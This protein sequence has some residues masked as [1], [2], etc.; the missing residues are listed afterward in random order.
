MSEVTWYSRITMRSIY[1][2]GGTVRSNR[3]RYACPNITF[4]ASDFNMLLCKALKSAGQKEFVLSNGNHVSLADIYEYQPIIVCAEIMSC[5]LTDIQ[6]AV[7][8]I[9]SNPSGEDLIKEKIKSMLFRIEDWRKRIEWASIQESYSYMLLTDLHEYIEVRWSAIYQEMC[10][11]FPNLKLDNLKGVWCSAM[12]ND[13]S[14]SSAQD[15]LF[16][17]GHQLVALIE[18]LQ[19]R[20]PIYMQEIMHNGNMDPSLSM[21]VYFLSKYAKMADSFNQR[22][23]GINDFYYDKVLGVKCREERNGKFWISAKIAHGFSPFTLPSNTRIW[24]KR[25]DKPICGRTLSDLVLT[26]VELNSLS[27]LEIGKVKERHPESDLNYVTNL[28]LSSFYPKDDDCDKKLGIGLRSSIF[29]LAGGHRHIKIHYVLTEDSVFFF[30]DMIRQVSQ[31]QQISE[32]EAQNKVLNESTFRVYLSTSVGLLE[33]GNFMMDYYETNTE[34]GISI[35]IELDSNFPAIDVLEGCSNPEIRMLVSNR[36]WLYPYSWCRKIKM[37]KVKVSVAV[38]GLRNFQV[39]NDLGQVD[40]TQ[41]FSPFGSS[42]V[43]GSWFVV[44]SEEMLNKR[45]SQVDLSLSWRGLPS[46]R[47]GMKGYY[48]SYVSNDSEIIDNTSFRVKGEYLSGYSWK[49]SLN[50]NEQYMFRTSLDEIPSPD[51]ALVEKS[52][53]SLSVPTITDRHLDNL[54]YEYGNV[55]CGFYRFVF[56]SPSMGFGESLYRKI[57]AETMLINSKIKHQLPIPKQPVMPMVDSVSLGYK[58][59]AET[60]FIAG[61]ASE[62]EVSYLQPAFGFSVRKDSFMYPIPLING[63]EEGGRL[64]ISFTGALGGSI[65]NFYL[66][67]NDMMVEM[68]DIPKINWS[69]RTEDGWINFPDSNVLSDTTNGLLESGYVSLLMPEVVSSDMLDAK[70]CLWISALVEKDYKRCA[71]AKMVYTNVVQ[72]EIEETDEEYNSI[73]GIESCTQVSPIKGERKKESSDEMQIRIKERISHRNRALLAGDYEKLILQ[74]FMQIDRVVCLSHVDVKK[75]GRSPLVT[76]VV[77]KKKQS[78]EK[79]PL[80]TDS[81][82]REMEVFLKNY[83]SPFVFVDVINPE[84]EYVTLFCGVKTQGGMSSG[85]IVNQV[86]RALEL[87]V[88]PWLSGE[89]SPALGRSFSVMDLQNAIRT[90]RGV[91]LVYGFKVIHVYSKSEDNYERDIY[92][93]AL[94]DNDEFRITPS[95]KWAVLCIEDVYV[96]PLIDE[97]EWNGVSGIGDF[98]IGDT[99]V[100]E[101]PESDINETLDC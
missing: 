39:H 26:P 84:Y 95:K 94:D 49:P 50:N 60:E 29:K 64:V 68:W 51:D 41:P 93:W 99:F 63:M 58:A 74:N 27:W 43:L 21:M 71:K 98:E 66:E 52:F 30:K 44:G 19:S 89:V 79:V 62:I 45:V 65:L 42:A 73:V 72:V 54:E 6:K 36:A 34:G 8:S 37:K 18:T 4:L 57:F 83:I 53:F 92:E 11:L 59:E 55:P 86:R 88:S 12:I 47:T 20:I 10:R 96:R 3:A 32:K 25:E 2:I 23:Q 38:D 16:R 87:C 82:L 46:D 67:L 80:C 100:V 31:C 17:T 1:N 77:L 9:N 13:I 7:H 61:G 5:D 76:L 85:N 78:I 48:S 22:L 35:S 28:T 33:T 101:A 24:I 56:T 90:I 70:G 14:L 91:S 15:F 75:I 40:V 97:E 81:E 69:Y